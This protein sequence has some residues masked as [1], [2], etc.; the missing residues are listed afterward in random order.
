[1]LTSLINKSIL[2]TGL[3]FVPQSNEHDVSTRTIFFNPDELFEKELSDSLQ[4]KEEQKHR[5]RTVEKGK[6]VLGILHTG[7]GQS[8]IFQNLLRVIKV[9]TSVLIR[10]LE[11]KRM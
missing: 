6:A 10:H 7:F 2:P 1:M 5:L 3:H 4:V 11:V 8:L 9:Q